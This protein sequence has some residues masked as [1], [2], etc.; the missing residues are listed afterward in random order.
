MRLVATLL[1]FR[2]AE[3]V[4]VTIESPAVV[5]TRF[6][7]QRMYM[8]PC[9]CSRRLVVSPVASNSSHWLTVASL[10][11]AGDVQPNPGPAPQ[12]KYPC[13]I[14]SRAVRSDQKGIFCEVCYEW[15]HTKCIGMPNSE[16][17]RLSASDEGWCCSRCHRTAFPFHDCSTISDSS[18]NDSLWVPSNCSR[19]VSGPI[20]SDIIQLVLYLLLKLSQSSP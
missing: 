7:D 5:H 4:S 9:L 14:C 13:G 20:T 12:W 17:Q 19:N 11:L 15:L 3:R 18:I 1:V 16:Y 10:L 8:W 6:D 2:V